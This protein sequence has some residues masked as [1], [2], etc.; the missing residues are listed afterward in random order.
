MSKEANSN[1]PTTGGNSAETPNTE[2][3]VVNTAEGSAAEAAADSV[4]TVTPQAESKFSQSDLDKAVAKALKDSAKKI[5]DAEARAKLSEEERTKAE[6]DDLRLQIKERDARDAVNVAAAKLGVKNSS[7]VY[8]LV[9]DDLEFDDKGKISNLAEV[10][11]SAKTEYPDLFDTKP[12]QSIDAGAGT[13]KTGDVLTKEK[14]AK[15]TPAEINALDWNDV[16]K[17]LT[18]K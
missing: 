18:A 12:N 15:M 16:Q 14:L 17:V 11:D 7:L 10:F 4:E 8:K 6:M 13:T 3:P 9:K 5:S 2:T 1:T